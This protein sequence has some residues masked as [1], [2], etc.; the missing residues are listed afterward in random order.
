MIIVFGMLVL[1]G[2]S[3]A[4]AEE[5]KLGRFDGVTIKACL[6][7]GGDYEKIYEKFSPNLRN[8]PVPK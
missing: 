6:I 4:I 1:S 3:L 2:L 8:S 5:L 7:G